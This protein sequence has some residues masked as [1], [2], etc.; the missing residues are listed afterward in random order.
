MLINHIS[1]L[2][3]HIV[4][5]HHAFRLLHILNM[6]SPWAPANC[7]FPK[8]SYLA[9]RSFKL[10]GWSHSSQLR[11]AS[12]KH[13]QGLPIFNH[14]VRP[15]DQ[16]QVVTLEECCHHIRPGERTDTTQVI[17][18]LQRLVSI[19]FY[20]FNSCI[21]TRR[22]FKNVLFDCNSFDVS[23]LSRRRRKLPGRS[24]PNPHSPC[25]CHRSSQHGNAWHTRN[26]Q[27][28]LRLPVWICP[29]PE[30]TST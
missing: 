5:L 1:S 23:W 13:S 20:W 14:L 28:S 29:Q 25:R 10:D 27:I 2:F 19:E 8:N 17:Q 22:P 3:H 26:W 30:A 12:L 6:S 21:R 4:I 9:A 24:Q 18:V 7:R 16:I 11:N 15:A